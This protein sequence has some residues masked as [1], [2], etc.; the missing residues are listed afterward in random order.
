M[1]NNTRHRIVYRCPEPGC[2]Y[3]VTIITT[4]SKP[5]PLCCIKHA[6]EWPEMEIY[7]HINL[8]T[9]EYVR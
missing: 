9:E 8:L 3:M 6:G 4:R 1:E 2:H 7:S 5:P